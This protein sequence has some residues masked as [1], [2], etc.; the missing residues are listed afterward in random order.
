MPTRTGSP[1]RAASASMRLFLL[2]SL[3]VALTPLADAQQPSTTPQR[4]YGRGVVVVGG[5][6]FAARDLVLARDTLTFTVHGSRDRRSY[7]LSRVDYASRIRS[8]V[9]RGHSS[10]RV[11]AHLRVARR[12]AGR[13]RFDVGPK[14]TRVPSLP[15]SRGGRAPR[16]D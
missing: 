8:H 9:L 15:R 16:R 5:E 1:H 7:P 6:R 2:V 3:S 4:T 10:W 13:G 12:R 11:E 14:T